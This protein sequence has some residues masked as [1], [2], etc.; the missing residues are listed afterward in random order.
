M[1]PSYAH[2]KDMQHRQPYGN[3]NGFNNPPVYRRGSGAPLEIV[4][5]RSAASGFLA[6]LL[7]AKYHSVSRLLTRFENTGFSQNHSPCGGGERC[8]LG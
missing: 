6:L 5:T 4:T 8:L 3:G 7:E 1:L 2:K